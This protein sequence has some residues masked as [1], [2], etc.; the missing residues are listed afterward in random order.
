MGSHIEDEYRSIMTG[1]GSPT[2]SLPPTWELMHAD[3][4]AFTERQYL[5]QPLVEKAFE[6]VPEPVFLSLGLGLGYN[7]LLIAFEALER[8]RK[9]ALIASYETAGF[10]KDAFAAWLRGAPVALTPVY[11]QITAL[12]AVRYAQAPA[13][14]KS[15]LLDLMQSD[16]FRLLGPIET[17][18]PSA[19]HGIL[20]DAFS[21]KTCPQLWTSEFLDVFFD[22]AAATPCFVSTHACN[23]KLKRALKKNGFTITI[24]D[25]F[26]RKWE[27]LWAQRNLIRGETMKAISEF[28]KPDFAIDALFYERWSPRVFNGEE[29]PDEVLNKLFEAARWAPSCFNEQP[30]RFLYAKRGSE[31]WNLFLGALVEMNQAWAGSASV[32]IACVSKKTFTRNGKPNGTHSFDAGAA[33]QN[34]ALQAH[35]LG[36]AAHGMAGVQYEKAAADLNITEDFKVEMMIAVGRTED[37]QGK[38][39]TPSG[40]NTVESFIT[41]GKWDK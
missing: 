20:F 11:D 5:Y 26:G 36:W 40:R 32:L 27:S 24:Q 9:P 39:W 22:R 41:K 16:R 1:D 6:A 3:E 17:G 21:P 4:G 28:R 29:I 30:W 8:G 23:G 33:W 15:F 2:L 18:E 10:L 13:A 34:L 35:L 38:E 7:E 37:L 12:Y 25:G 31:D 14:A 19:A